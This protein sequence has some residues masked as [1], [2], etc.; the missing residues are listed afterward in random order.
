MAEQDVAAL[1]ARAI[2]IAEETA[3]TQAEISE[4]QA[5]IVAKQDKIQAVQGK[6]RVIGRWLVV[7]IPLDIL[8]TVLGLVVTFYLVNF[9][10]Q[11][12][13]AQAAQAA[14]ERQLHASQL[15]G[16]A[17]GNKSRAAQIQLWDHVIAISSVPPRETPAQKTARLAK[18][19]GFRAYVGQTFR[20]I[21]C[22]ALYRK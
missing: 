3:R 21:D 12:H 10:G 4:T 2:G 20:Q 15:A 7:L 8:V 19:A 13:R 14:V 17:I 22:A 16:C 9:S 6:L 11:L 5:A 1:A 18:L